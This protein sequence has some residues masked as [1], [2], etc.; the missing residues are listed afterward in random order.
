MAK[1]ESRSHD[2]CSQCGA[3]V[4]VEMHGPWSYRV[5]ARE[6]HLQPQGGGGSLASA[7]MIFPVLG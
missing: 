2:K 1:Y 5:C 7:A 6:G 4:V 3:P